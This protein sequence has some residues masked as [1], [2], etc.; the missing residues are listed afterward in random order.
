MIGSNAVVDVVHKCRTV[1]F[2]G[3][4]SLFVFGVRYTL[5]TLGRHQL[6]V[7]DDVRHV[8]HIP[9]QRESQPA[10]GAGQRTRI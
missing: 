10:T 4:Q 7:R 9:E 5:P 2:A 8:N 1:L 3:G 6:A